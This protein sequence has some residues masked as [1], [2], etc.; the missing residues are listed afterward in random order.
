MK[1]SEPVKKEGPV[2]T[3]EDGRTRICIQRK[4]CKGCE[5]C[6]EFCP[7]TTLAMEGDKPVVADLS[8]CTRCMLCE[9]RCPDFAIEVTDLA[10]APQKPGDCKG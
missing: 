10:K 7:Q 3:Y 9:L 5:I 2:W 4:W 8:T 1:P 6:V